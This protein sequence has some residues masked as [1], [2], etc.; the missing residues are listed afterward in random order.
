MGTRIIKNYKLLFWAPLTDTITGELFHKCDLLHLVTHGNR[1][2]GCI[3]KSSGS[4]SYVKHVVYYTDILNVPLY[5]IA[6]CVLR[7]QSDTY[8]VD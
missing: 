5:A 2:L 4:Y 1:I 7:A 8:I 6:I 3:L